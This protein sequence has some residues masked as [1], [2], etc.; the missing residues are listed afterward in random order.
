MKKRS[1]A[2]PG[3]CDDLK[4]EYRFDYAVARPNS[5]APSLKGRAIAVVL[6]PEVA[7]AF[8]TSESV[9]TALRAVM[10]AVPRRSTR[11]R[12]KGVRERS[13]QLQRTKSTKATSRGRR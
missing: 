2:I 7:A 11:T 8:P 5:Y 6:D 3:D 1:S 9:N 13:K 12:P 10:V 4:P